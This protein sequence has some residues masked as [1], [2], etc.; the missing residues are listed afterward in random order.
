MVRSIYVLTHHDAKDANEPHHRTA[1]LACFYLVVDRLPLVG[2]LYG[3]SSFVDPFPC[4]S[5][6]R[7]RRKESGIILGIGAYASP[8]CGCRARGIAHAN[9]P[10]HQG[11]PVLEFG[12]GCVIRQVFLKKFGAIFPQEPIENS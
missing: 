9:A 7:D 12:T 8:V 3:C 2:A 4:L 5:I 6:A 1:V 11:T 10:F